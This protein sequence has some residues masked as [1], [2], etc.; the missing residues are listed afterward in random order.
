MW[1]AFF[2]PLV[3]VP[4]FPALLENRARE[5]GKALRVRNVLAAGYRQ[6]VGQS[7]T[8]G[9][10]AAFTDLCPIRLLGSR[11][12]RVRRLSSSQIC[13]HFSASRC[14]LTCLRYSDSNG[15]R[16]DELGLPVAAESSTRT[17]NVLELSLA[18]LGHEAAERPRVSGGSEDRW[19]AARPVCRLLSPLRITNGQIH[20]V[21]TP[22]WDQGVSTPLGVQRSS[23]PHPSSPR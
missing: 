7:L 1:D 17:T 10:Q 6:N 21:R 19:L 2:L 22:A 8:T 4:R 9:E 14:H 5:L 15:L 18:F 11:H 20:S 16:I 23:T 12:G 3:A 13:E